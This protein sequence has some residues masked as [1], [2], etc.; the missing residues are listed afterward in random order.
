MASWCVT[1]G[2]VAPGVVVQQECFTNRCVIVGMFYSK[3]VSQI[4][5][6]LLE[7][8]T[9]RLFH[10]WMLCYCWNVLQ[11]ECFA[12]RR[13]IFV[14][15][16]YEWLLGY[17]GYWST[18][19]IS[20]RVA[21]RLPGA[22]WRDSPIVLQLTYCTPCS[23]SVDVGNGYIAW[24]LAWFSNSCKCICYIHEFLLQKDQCLLL[25]SQYTSAKIIWSN[26]ELII[27]IHA[28]NWNAI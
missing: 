6:L 12:F 26:D 25:F 21:V 20:A 22:C 2:N 18:H 23:V 1:A 3:I 4:D 24:S 19:L 28:L 15:M 27:L 9:A 16:F 11:Q 14:G 7:C 13:F 5:V 10:K 17:H 8:F